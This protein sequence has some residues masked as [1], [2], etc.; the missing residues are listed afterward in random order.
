[1]DNDQVI[2]VTE[3]SKA[4][5]YERYK[6]QR[7]LYMRKIEHTIRMGSRQ[8]VEEAIHE[9]CSNLRREHTS[10]FTFRLL[11]DEVQR[12]LMAQWKGEE[13][14]WNQIYNVFTLSRCISMDDFEQLLLEAC[15]MLLDEKK[16]AANAQSSLVEQAI[17]AIRNKYSSADLNISG[18]ADT[19]NVSPV[20]LAVEFKNETG[21]SPSDYLAMIRMEEAK[22]LL[23]DTDLLVREICQRVGYEDDHVFIRRF[24]KYSGKTPGQF[25]REN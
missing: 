23:S 17:Q 24:K 22:R 2:R 9:L 11:A 16:D 1:M 6:E 10:M 8:E 7:E 13:K 20:T 25:R 15:H 19:L 4:G 18:L 14:Q 21:I 12:M 5:D 3:T